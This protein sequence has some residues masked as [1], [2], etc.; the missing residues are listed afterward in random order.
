MAEYRNISNKVHQSLLQTA[1]RSPGQR[2]PVAGYRLYLTT[3]KEAEKSLGQASPCTS[4]RWR[5][6]GLDPLICA[7]RTSPI[8]FATLIKKLIEEAEGKPR[9]RAGRRKRVI[10]PQ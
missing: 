5:Q 1:I 4:A 7:A 8:W 9:A 6:A 3:G 2:A 10:C